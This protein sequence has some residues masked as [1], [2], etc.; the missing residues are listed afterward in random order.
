M[1][2]GQGDTARGDRRQA[3]LAVAVAKAEGRRQ[4]AGGTILTSPTADREAQVAADCGPYQHLPAVGLDHHSPLTPGLEHQRAG[5]PIPPH[6]L[7]RRM[8][9]RVRVPRADNRHTGGGGLDQARRA[10][11]SAAVMRDLDDAKRHWVERAGHAA[12]HLPPDD[13]ADRDARGRGKLRRGRTAPDHLYEQSAL[14][15]P[16]QRRPPH[17]LPPRLVGHTRVAVGRRRT[18]R[19]VDTHDAPGAP[20]GGPARPPAPTDRQPHAAR[21]RPHGAGAADPRHRQTQGH[22]V[23][24]R[25]RVGTQPPLEQHR[26]HAS[27]VGAGLVGEPPRQR[28]LEGGRVPCRPKQQATGREAGDEHHRH[29]DRA[30]AQTDRRHRERPDHHEHDP[31]PGQRQRQPHAGHHAH[32]QRHGRQRRRIRHVGTNARLVAS[33]TARQRRL[34]SAGVGF[35]EPA[36]CQRC[37]F[38]RGRRSASGCER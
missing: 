38:C 13:P 28:C 15:R 3:C 25:H 11:S 36:V 2:G 20:L 23:V 1:A 18:E 6:H 17:R 34:I 26:P 8:T 7:R 10:R 37:D 4:E 16:K 19:R 31:H 32:Q 29:R 24:G 22:A 35:C 5:V 12:L 14:H 21:G 27:G 33:G 9:K 30:R